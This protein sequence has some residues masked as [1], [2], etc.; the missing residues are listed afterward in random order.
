MQIDEKLDGEM[1]G[2]MVRESALA[3]RAAGFALLGA[4]LAI[5]AL[6]AMP[7][8]FRETDR[9]DLRAL[10]AAPLAGAAG[11]AA[12]AYAARRGLETVRS[13][14]VELLSENESVPDS[15]AEP[16]PEAA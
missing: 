11:A 16:P 10:S 1:A 13:R 14:K 7:S 6:V 3:N 8:A 4:L 5:V 12:R 2:L 15:G 9:T